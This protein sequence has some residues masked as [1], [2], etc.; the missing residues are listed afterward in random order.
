[1]TNVLITGANRGIGLELVRQYLERGHFVFAAARAPQKAAELA[2]LE[3]PADGRLSVL[4]LDV[5][6]ARQRAALAR[7]LGDKPLDIL[8]NNAGIIGP[9]RQSTLSMDFDGFA[10][11]LEVNTIAPLAVV[12]A[13]LDR[14]Q[15][16]SG[17]KILTIT[18]KMGSFGATSQSDRIAYRASKAAVNMVMR[19]LARDLRGAGVAIALAHPG[20]VRTDMGGSGA[21][22]SPEASANG[23]ISAIDTLTLANTGCFIDWTG[24]AID[25]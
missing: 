2:A 13:L 4:Q 8:I 1:M 5:T 10:R 21:D 16:A 23:L 11:T 17:A 9:G 22:I 7:E 25:W 24:Q 19:G 12:Q 15:A 3:A 6:D 18:S 20:W 14:L